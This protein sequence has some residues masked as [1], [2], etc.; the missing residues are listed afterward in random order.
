MSFVKE[1]INIVNENDIADVQ[2]GLRK[3]TN[4][5]GDFQTETRQHI[6]QNYSDF[7][8]MIE[9]NNGLLGQANRLAIEVDT[10]Y[11]KIDTGTKEGIFAMAGDVQQ[12]LNEMEEIRIGVR[13]NQRLVRIDNLFR[14]LEL[15]Q[16]SNQIS[17][18]YDTLDQLK[19]CIFE[20]DDHDIFLQLDCYKNLKLR[21]HTERESFCTLLREMFAS[22]VQMDERS[23]QSSKCAVIKISTDPKLHQVFY[24]LLQT[25]YNAQS[26]YTFFMRNV[27]E[28]IL[29]RPVSFEVKVIKDTQ[30]AAEYNVIEVSFSRKQIGAGERNLRPNYKHVFSHLTKT[31]NAL[32]PLN[33][34]VPSKKTTFFQQMAERV[35]DEFYSMLI[36]E[37]LEFSIPERIDDL[38]KS[39]LAKEVMAFDEFLKSIKFV[40]DTNASKLHEFKEKIEVIFKKRFCMDILD[41]AVQIM[42]KDLHEMQIVEETNPDGGNFP[43]CMV[44]RSTFDLINLMQQILKESESITASSVDEYVLADIKQRLRQT[45][46]TILK[47]Y[48]TEIL[49]AHSKLLQTIPQQ[50][51]LFHNN[52]AYLAWWFSRC[53]IDGETDSADYKREETNG[54][55]LEFGT[56][57]FATQITNQRTQL[58]E[59]LREIGKLKP[60]RSRSKMILM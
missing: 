17:N 6:D 50:A 18:I 46:P 37:C 60:N 40:N 36:S 23:F 29:T 33:I 58:V 27:F 35:A 47:K 10:L 15:L 44:S 3:L 53:D 22:M 57:Q 28:P 4:E 1:I 12:Y 52:C 30:H 41:R 14:Q 13:V 51:A 20:H 34:I 24:L 11:E 42:R 43:R 9:E 49:E 59:L 31:F 55:L 39:D 7:K 19:K 48:P 26:L 5:I 32:R 25:S 16:E 8:E 2:S 56:N 54:R 38:C 45:I 21:F